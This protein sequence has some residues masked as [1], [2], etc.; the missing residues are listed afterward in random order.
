[1][2][3]NI[4]LKKFIITSVLLIISFISLYSQSNDFKPLYSFGIKQGINSSSVSFSP[5][6]DQGLTLG[7]T[8]GL[9]FKYQNEKLFGL[10]VELN[11]IQKGWTENLDTISNSYERRLNYIELPFITQI[12][13]GKRPNL[14]YYINIG[15]SFAYLLAEKET[16][17]VN[18]EL[19]RR[20]YYEKEVENA[21]DY[22]VLGELGVTYN[23]NIGEFQV[24]VRYQLTF[25]DLFDVT[26]DTFFDNSQNQLFGL[27]LTYFFFDNK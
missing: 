17:E 24:G 18:N 22:S 19:Y 14:K 15:T 26:E 5:G 4:V 2:L 8:G 9:V 13:L 16:V 23:T 10:Q 27:S 7:Y 20:E 11:Y 21:F 1:M 25:T 3:N 6:I 12:I